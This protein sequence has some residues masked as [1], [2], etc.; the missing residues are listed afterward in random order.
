[1]NKM[2]KLDKCRLYQLFAVMHLTYQVLT[3]KKKAENDHNF[4]WEEMYYPPR[5]IKFDKFTQCYE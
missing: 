3:A 5:L 1:M 4:N 2:I